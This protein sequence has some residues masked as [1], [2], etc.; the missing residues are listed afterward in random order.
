MIMI[1]QRGSGSEKKRRNNNNDDDDDDDDDDDAPADHGSVND[2]PVSQ[3]TRVDV[4]LLDDAL[5]HDGVI[6]EDAVV[7]ERNGN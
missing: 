6:A 4:G 1:G 3:V 2:V 5:I 7:G